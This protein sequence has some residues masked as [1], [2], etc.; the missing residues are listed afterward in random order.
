MRGQGV[1]DANQITQERLG[2][3]LRGSASISPARR[4]RPSISPTWSMLKC[5]VARGHSYGRNTAGGAVN[6]ISQKPTGDFDVK[7]SVDG[8]QRDYV[9]ALGTMNLPTV[10]GGL[11]SKVT[12]LYSNLAGNVQK[13]A[14]KTTT[15]RTR[16]ARAPRCAGTPAAPFPDYLLEVGELDSTTRSTTRTQRSPPPSSRLPS[17]RRAGLQHLGADC[18]ANQRSALQLRRADAG[19]QVERSKYDQVTDVLSRTRFALLPGLRRRI[20]QPCDRG[21]SFR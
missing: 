1:A 3:S 10:A 18:A 9:R 4:P 21:R 14:A 17:H 12:L 15:A 8:G 16:K 5:C 6:I 19:F 7:F 20:Y 13:Q 11:S 2:G